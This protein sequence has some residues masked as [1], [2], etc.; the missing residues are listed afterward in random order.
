MASG[1]QTVVNQI[2]APA[3]AGDFASAN[4]NRFS[5]L[6][7]PGGLV[8]GAAGV[9]VGHF[10]WLSQQSLDPDNA[11]QIVNSF[12]VPNAGAGAS[13]A[14]A[15]DGFVSRPDSPAIITT[16]LADS[17]MVIQQ[18]S[19]V[20]LKSGGDFWCK[21][22]GSGAAVVGN[23][24]YASLTTGAVSFAATGTPSTATSTSSTIAAGTW[25]A[26]GS[27]A[28]NVMTVGTVTGTYGVAIGATVTGTNVVSGTVVVA[29]LTGSNGGAGTYAVSI[30]EQAV[31]AATSLSGTFGVLTIGG[32][33]A[34]AFVVGGI[35]STGSGVTAGTTIT[36]STAQNT[37]FT[38]AGGAGTY[39]VNL[40]QA[41]GGGGETMDFTTNV[42]TK[43]AA[44][45][46]GA[47]GEVVKISEVTQ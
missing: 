44:R 19:Q 14:G 3:V 31:A 36:C 8:S 38:G 11:A 39:A 20:P 37:N 25:S 16:Y 33:V 17:T 34:G 29:Q 18:G 43:W 30:G 32:T 7:G 9:I 5:V 40:T 26:T 41:V 42:E 46:S 47:A 22:D 4:Y 10:A 21:N 12:Y 27:I 24:A 6:S 15:P 23:K 13:A 45:S 28:G 1:I 2:P 35:V